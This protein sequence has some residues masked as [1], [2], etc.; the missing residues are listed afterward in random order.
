MLD[1][2]GI[3]TLSFE[4]VDVRKAFST[5]KSRQADWKEVLEAGLRM[6]IFSTGQSR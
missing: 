5:F 6:N 2:A 4:H 3:S 1:K